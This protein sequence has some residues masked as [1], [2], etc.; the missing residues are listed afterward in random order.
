[1][2]IPPKMSVSEFPYLKDKRTQTLFDRHPEFRVKRGDKDFWAR[3]DYVATV[4]NVNEETI[5]KYI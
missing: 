5:W 1:M 3:G 4:G 2:A